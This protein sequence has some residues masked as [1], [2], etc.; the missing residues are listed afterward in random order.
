MSARDRSD[1]RNAPNGREAPAVQTSDDDLSRFG[2]AV[3]TLF[4][5]RLHQR[6]QITNR[7]VEILYG[8]LTLATAIA[9]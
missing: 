9:G 4:Q 3:P 1:E 5:E 2:I 8:K 6:Y 7:I